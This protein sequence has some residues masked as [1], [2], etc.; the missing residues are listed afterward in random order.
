M[1]QPKLTH[2]KCLGDEKAKELE[3]KL[4][5]DELELTITIPEG[6]L[7]KVVDGQYDTNSR[8]VSWHQKELHVGSPVSLIIHFHRATTYGNGT[9]GHKP[10]NRDAMTSYMT[11]ILFANGHKKLEGTYKVS[12]ENWTVSQLH[13]AQKCEPGSGDFICPPNGVCNS[14]EEADLKWMASAVKYKTI[15]GGNLDIDLDSLLQ[16]TRSAL[17][18]LDG[19]SSYSGSKDSVSVVR[20]EPLSIAPSDDIVNLVIEYLEK[21]NVFI[22][23]VIEAPVSIVETEDGGEQKRSWEISGRYYPN[24]SQQAES[25]QQIYRGGSELGLHF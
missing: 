14:L 17:S 15:I 18:E 21:Q 7:I 13:V 12:I 8:K 1:D 5:L 11:S 22:E 23:E 20:Q 24:Q 4:T 2:T 9:N 16:P 6:W 25:L 3:G 10:L 19:V